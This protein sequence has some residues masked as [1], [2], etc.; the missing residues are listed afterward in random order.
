MH[1]NFVIFIFFRQ[2][3]TNILFVWSCYNYIHVLAI[4][5][6]IIMITNQ[7]T[8]HVCLLYRIVQAFS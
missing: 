2:L 1:I 8:I 6:L 5:I 7:E 3:I 4:D